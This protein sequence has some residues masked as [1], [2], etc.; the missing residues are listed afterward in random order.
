[1]NNDK[2]D[3]E[4]GPHAGEDESVWGGDEPCA[5]QTIGKEV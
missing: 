3:R 4:C 1:M 5:P 2:T